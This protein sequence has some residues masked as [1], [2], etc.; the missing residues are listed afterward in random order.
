MR[1][2]AM[3]AEVFVAAAH[4]EYMDA[5]HSRE[6]W[7]Q[8]LR[9]PRDRRELAR[10]LGI[11]GDSP[12]MHQVIVS[13]AQIAPTDSTVLVT[14]ETGTGKDLVARGIHTL[15]RRRT[16]PFMALNVSAL[17][18][19][20]L[21]SELFG[22]EKGAFTSAV[23][24]KKG[25]F[26]AAGNGTVFLDEIGDIS[27][28]MQVRLLRVLEEREFRRVGGD[29]VLRTD[30]RFVAATNVNLEY[31]VSDGSFRQ[32]LYYRLKVFEIHL[33][34]LRERKDDIPLLVE[35]FVER[36]CQDNQR[37]VPVV[38]N[39]ARDMFLS[40]DWPG[41]VRELRT[42]VERMMV[43]SQGAVIHAEDVPDVLQEKVTS[44][45]F[46]PALPKKQNRG[47]EFELG[48]IY[49]ALVELRA[50]MSELRHV[51]TEFIQAGDDSPWFENARPRGRTSSFSPAGDDDRPT[52]D[53]GVMDIEVEVD[54]SG[55]EEQ[56]DSAART[57]KDMER[58]A[59]RQAL[60]DVDGN[61][62]EAAR[63]LGIGERTLYRKL[64]EY[65]L[66]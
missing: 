8:S 29:R 40:Y 65:H 30:S 1:F 35:F 14:G 38:S 44:R 17:N 26:E 42:V 2:S 52:S 10:R 16:A 13:I 12:A 24:E 18:E 21:E 48:I 55:D 31:A 4:G 3:L 39:E 61:R 20:T 63:R 33:P 49:R 36:F 23:R 19:G 6:N 32:D 34:P 28:A 22:H 60:R 27:P 46:L 25:I 45:G 41:N 43:L 64:R 54:A 57:L 62:R 66:S 53:D 59:I 58:E 11:V 50:E 51:V 37:D 5:E 9:K 56:D 47:E 15:S 7:P